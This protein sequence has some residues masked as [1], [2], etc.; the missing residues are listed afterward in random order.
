MSRYFDA[1]S[2]V[3]TGTEA[4]R[5]AALTANDPLS[6]RS[7]PWQ[8]SLSFKVTLVVVTLGFLGMAILAGF[9]YWAMLMVD[10]EAADREK[11]LISRA[12]DEQIAAVKRDQQK[13]TVGDDP[14]YMTRLGDEAWM[15]EN[16]GAWMY[17]SYGHEWGY[18]L[19]EKDVAIYAMNEGITVPTA[20]FEGVSRRIAPLV[21]KVRGL[22]EEDREIGD[23]GVGD[24]M[25]IDGK[26]SMVTIK[27]IVPSTERETLATGEEYLHVAVKHVD[28][29][30]FASLGERYLV[31]NVRFRPR[32]ATS[33][34]E[35]AVPLVGERAWHLGYLVWDRERPGLKLIRE[36]APGLGTASLVVA[37]LLVFLLT[38]IRRAAEQVHSSEE[39][40]QHLAT[41]DSLTG[42]PNRALLYQ[43][44]DEMLSGGASEEGTVALHCVDLDRFKNV[45]DTLGHPAGD[46][47]IRR[48]AARLSKVAGEENLV[49]RLG[50]DEFAIV[51]RGVVGQGDAQRL[52]EQTMDV[53]A[54]PF[55][56]LGN[57]VFVSASMGIVL[58]SQSGTGRS[59]L[60]RK[61]DI[62]L[63]EAKG[64][65]KGQ[66]CLFY[67]ELDAAVR[68]KQAIERD[69]RDAL[70]NG[71]GL[72]LAYQPIYAINGET[73]LGAEAL[74]RWEHPTRGALSPAVFV[75]VAEERGLIRQLGL[76]VL[77]EACHTA[78]TLGLPWIAVNVS[79]IQFRDRAF[80]GQVLRLL[81]E[82][83]LAPDRLQLEI[84]EGLFLD[85]T[86]EVREALSV[87]RSTGVR[88]ALDDFGTG[89]SSL[90]YLHRYE[91]D[92]I[93][94]DRSFVQRLDFLQ[95]RRRDRPGNARSRPCPRSL[96]HRRRG[97]NSRPTAKARCLRMH[98]TPG[99]SALEAD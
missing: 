7:R 69:L 12:I 26:P 97:G 93:K 38:R 25:W 95:G 21:Q 3:G 94:I 23:L 48:V 33:S 86:D 73:I 8:R 87:L 81:D 80:A 58:A 29:A 28:S 31:S 89:Y 78:K 39:R 20:E 35:N 91:L 45:N 56:I 99:L 67:P 84:T 10:A 64:A 36:A 57:Q 72:Q 49:A 50:G 68:E 76:W 54:Q 71:T 51:Q 52:A 96:R 55:D 4:A 19:D 82:L 22:L 16:V 32:E 66:Y 74:V 30:F 83:S 27:P 98:R 46:T 92:K 42:L 9:T 15:A 24:V 41:H 77:R 90:Q 75:P 40:F 88:I 70:E 6:S 1:A 79:A 34:G 61:A 85:L 17:T 63:Y 43:K 60:I 14:F 37:V 47:L 53:M 65:G 13:V 5:G 18:V 59:D 44:L 62:A 2:S 11:T